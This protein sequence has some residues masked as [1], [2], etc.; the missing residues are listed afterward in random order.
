MAANSSEVDEALELRR[1]VFVG[2]QGVTLEADRDGLDQVALH[3]VA[4]DG[5]NVVGTCR[6]VFDGPLARLGRMAVEDDYRGRGLG[7]AILAE[8]EHQALAAG[9]ERIRLHAQLAARSLYE[10]SGFVVQGQEFMEEG[11][12]HLTMEK[13]LA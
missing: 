8:A 6:L 9:S 12:P 5:G 13:P 2:Q 4:I 1:R 11:I 3:V 7:A 10:R